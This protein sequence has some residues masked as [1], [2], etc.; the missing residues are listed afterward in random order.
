MHL[1]DIEST[2][3]SSTEVSV[4]IVRTAS[5]RVRIASARDGTSPAHKADC[6]P[7]GKANRNFPPEPV[8]HLFGTICTSL[9]LLEEFGK[10]MSGVSWDNLEFVE[11]FH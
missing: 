1:V 3:A 2:D 10:T 6:P 9:A 8:R 4:S 5:W 7:E 11:F